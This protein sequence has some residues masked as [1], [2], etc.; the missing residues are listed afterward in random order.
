MDMHAGVNVI[1]V[2][3]RMCIGLWS[4]GISSTECSTKCLTI[5][6]PTSSC[7]LPRSTAYHTYVRMCVHLYHQTKSREHIAC[8]CGP[9]CTYVLATVGVLLPVLPFSL[10]TMHTVYTVHRTL[11]RQYLLYQPPLCIVSVL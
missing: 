3:C 4:N 5:Q 11:S 1:R 9:G 8:G 2:V 7:A 10:C 6:K